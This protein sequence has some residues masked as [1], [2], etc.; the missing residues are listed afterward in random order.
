M[1]TIGHNHDVT[2]KVS[3]MGTSAEPTARLVLGTIPELSFPATK[4]GDL[5]CANVRIPADMEAGSYPIRVEVIVNNRHFTPLV[6]QVELC[7]VAA[8]EAPVSSETGVIEPQATADIPPDEVA[9]EPEEIAFT[10]TIAPQDETQPKTDVP[11]ISIIQMVADRERSDVKPVSE[12]GEASE[13]PVQPHVAQT[14]II[15]ALVAAPKPELSSL[16]KVVEAPVAKAFAPVVTPLPKPTEATALPVKVK[17]SDVAKIAETKEPP[18][19]PT[20]KKQQPVVELK[21]GV[22]VRLVKGEIIYE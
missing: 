15:D 7:K 16:Q 9:A 20:Q 22:P 18:R 6:K 14:S 12:V 21:T 17:L 10:A 19:K 4:T 1:L 11:R 8:A 2:F 3:V 5:W 13:T